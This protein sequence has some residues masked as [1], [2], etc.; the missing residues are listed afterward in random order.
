VIGFF[1]STSRGDSERLIVAFNQ[2]LKLG[3]HTEGQN[4]AIEYRWAETMSMGCQRWPAPIEP[5]RTRMTNYVPPN[6]RRQG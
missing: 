5:A 2:G 1:R 6:H 4:V 3:G